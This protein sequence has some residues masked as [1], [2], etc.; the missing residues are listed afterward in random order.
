MR[1]PIV[2]LALARPTGTGTD[3]EAIYDEPSASD[4]RPHTLLTSTPPVAVLPS[5]S[6]PA[7]RTMERYHLTRSVDSE[8]YNLEVHEHDRHDPRM[9]ALLTELDLLTYSEPTFSRFTLGAFLRFGRVFTITADGLVIGATHCMRSYDDPEEVV[10]FNMALRP[11]WRGHGLG[12]RFLHG[13][14]EKL[15]AGGTRSVSLVVAA[16]NGRAIAVYRTKFGFEDVSTLE[17]EFGNGHEYVLMRL[18]L[19]RP[20]PGAEVEDTDIKGAGAPP[21]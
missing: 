3:D 8:G 10:I 17:N 7:K 13:I 6:L 19:E 12:T 16:A 1:R 2:S 21:N 9:I 18:S 4:T 14:L 20:L 5:P 15:Q 11:G